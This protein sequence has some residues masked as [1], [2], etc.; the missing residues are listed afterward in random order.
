MQLNGTISLQM[1]LGFRIYKQI[2]LTMPDLWDSISRKHGVRGRLTVRIWAWKCLLMIGIESLNVQ[3]ANGMLGMAWRSLEI[4]IW[5]TTFVEFLQVLF[6]LLTPPILVLFFCIYSI[7]II[8]CIRVTSLHQILAIM[9][10]WSLI[11]PCIKSF[12]NKKN[13][14]FFC[15]NKPCTIWFSS[16]LYKRPKHA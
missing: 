8:E 13:S 3:Q 6:Q 14:I 9:K 5:F 7:Y 15:P 12:Q 2:M 4:R 1:F 16:Q 11:H 10:I